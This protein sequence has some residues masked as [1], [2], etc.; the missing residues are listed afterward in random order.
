MVVDFVLNQCE[1]YVLE[2]VVVVVNSVTSFEQVLY[3]YTPNFF[4][5]YVVAPDTIRNHVKT[6]HEERRNMHYLAPEYGKFLYWT[7]CCEHFIS[8]I[9]TFVITLPFLQVFQERAGSMIRLLMSLLLEF[10]H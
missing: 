8:L 2:N 9:E 1:C 5:L 10:V 7:V 4:F 3:N 6:Y